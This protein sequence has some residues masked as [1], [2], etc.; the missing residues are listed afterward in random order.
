MSEVQ[1][2]LSQVCESGINVD[3]LNYI[4]IYMCVF[5]SET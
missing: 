3:K 2:Q 4:Y 1:I 5:S